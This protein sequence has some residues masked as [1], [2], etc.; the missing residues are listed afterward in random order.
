MSKYSEQTLEALN[1]DT[2]DMEVICP[3]CNAPNT[4]RYIVDD[5]VE[6]ECHSCHKKYMVA[7]K[8]YCDE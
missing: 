5:S 1:G 2:Q 4:I 3:L 6:F 8:V 7:V